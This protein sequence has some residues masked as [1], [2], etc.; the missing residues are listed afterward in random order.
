MN[1]QLKQA[2][3]K[4]MG[5]YGKGLCAEELKNKEEA[6]SLYNQALNLDPDLKVAEERLL[7]LNEK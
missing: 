4:A 1:W 2:P 6:I 5:Y 3:A 7:I